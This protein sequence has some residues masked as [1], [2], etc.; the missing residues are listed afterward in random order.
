MR[1]MEEGKEKK[2]YKNDREISRKNKINEVFVV[3]IIIIIIIIIIMII[4]PSSIFPFFYS[5]SHSII[6]TSVD[7]L[8]EEVSSPLLL[9][10]SYLLSLCSDHASLP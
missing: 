7:F 5:Y 8:P 6:I 9:L 10:H 3:I 2:R 1:G 4:D